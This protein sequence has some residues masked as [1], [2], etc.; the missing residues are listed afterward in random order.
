LACRRQK[1]APQYNRPRVATAG[2]IDRM[3]FI[4]Q[5]DSIKWTDSATVTIALLSFGV[6]V[7]AWVAAR[8]QASVSQRSVAFSIFDRRWKVFDQTMMLLVASTNDRP[9]VII[10]HLQKTRGRE[11]LLPPDLNALVGEVHQHA[12]DVAHNERIASGGSFESND[13]A[14]WAE[15]AR[16]LSERTAFLIQEVPRRFKQVLDFTDM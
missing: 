8:T 7:A 3:N 9:G 10:N 16:K 15:T 13:R 14:A 6:S 12:I 4:A 1:R 5:A 2:G 11:F